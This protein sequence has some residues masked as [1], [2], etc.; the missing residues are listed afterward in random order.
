[1]PDFARSYHLL[2]PSAFALP[3]IANAAQMPGR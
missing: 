2:P 1:M 3:P